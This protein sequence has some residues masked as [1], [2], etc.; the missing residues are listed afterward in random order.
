MN[1][2]YNV[3]LFVSGFAGVYLQ[4]LLLLAT[5]IL[6]ACLLENRRAIMKHCYDIKFLK[7]TYSGDM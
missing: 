5:A 2:T 4:N 3:S 6:A 1:Y 7:K